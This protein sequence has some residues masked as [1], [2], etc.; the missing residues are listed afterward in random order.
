[1]QDIK[2]R[3]YVILFSTLII[4]FAFSVF[5]MDKNKEDKQFYLDKCLWAAVKYDQL[6]DVPLL[7]IGGAN[8]NFI[9]PYTRRNYS[10]LELAI[11][12][13][14]NELVEQLLDHHGNADVGLRL[15][16]NFENDF[17]LHMVEL[18][19]NKGAKPTGE[20]LSLAISR[21][22]IKM[23]KL[24]MSH[25]ACYEDEIKNY[26]PYFYAYFEVTTNY[27]N[28]S[29]QVFPTNYG[30]LQQF[31]EDLGIDRTQPCYKGKSLDEWAAETA[32]G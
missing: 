20:H 11:L 2:M 23:T 19:I 17:A 7:L 13:Q 6:K 14:N 9:S 30:E 21:N 32:G 31:L 26:R 1:M 8:P 15:V 24:L 27:A 10:I 28:S 5:S 29:E 16:S 18:F 22:H 4:T 25:G 3:L 12:K